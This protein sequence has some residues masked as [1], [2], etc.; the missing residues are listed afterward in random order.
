MFFDL[1]E[2]EIVALSA[3]KL[4]PHVDV[5]SF[6]SYVVLHPSTTSD[7]AYQW[8]AAGPG[9]TPA[10]RTDELVRKANSAREKSEDRNNWIIEP[11]LPQHIAQAIDWL[12]TRAKI[13]IMGQGGDHTAYATAGMMISY[14]ISAEKAVE[15]MWQYWNPRCSPPWSGDEYEHLEQKVTHAYSYNT[16]PPG[17][18]TEAYQAARRS[19]LFKP[20]TR[21]V[22][23]VDGSVSGAET[24][25]G[26]FRFVDR[27]GMEGIKPPEWLIRDLIPTQSYAIMY[28]ARG[29][30]KSFLALD[31][32]LCVA[33][34]GVWPRP[35]QQLWKSVPVRGPV[36]YIAGEGRAQLK[37]RV[38]AWEIMFNGGE[39]VNNF[40]L[41]D[42]VP[43]AG[44]DD[45]I[46]AF[47]DGALEVSEY[48]YELI[49]LDTVG[50]ALQGLNENSQQDAS[51]F[52][53]MVDYFRSELGAATLALTHAGK[54]EEQGVRGSTVFEADADTVLHVTRREKEML[55]SVR[56]TKQKD[57]V[58]L[59]DAVWAKLA[60]VETQPDV[61]S[62]VAIAADKKE[63][64]AKIVDKGRKEKQQTHDTA[65]VIMVLDLAVKKLLAANKIKEWSTR[66]LAEAM[67]MRAEIEIASKTLQNKN[68]VS[69]RETQGTVA[70][71]S[72]DP[73]KKRWRHVD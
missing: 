67:A 72:Y 12:K 49:V 15:L 9:A 41:A 58:E 24:Q 17:N 19:E 29:T 11:D 4:A 55:V 47:I 7:G 65:A 73:S 18:I 39:R 44:L 16:S 57:D 50:R 63:V 37:K 46:G 13:A 62:L 42:P 43:N 45:E 59:E 6:H 31:L 70:N 64:V 10:F 66:E 25:A 33:T 36:L 3:S 38:R 61:K 48:G 54:S 56:V 22:V 32:A 71:K 14:G 53:R 21:E 8:G 40:I 28:G 69:L 60:E 20:I 27:A 1:A 68:L 51:R 23:A 2:G 52:T 5:R 34:G 35:P 30:F 26:R